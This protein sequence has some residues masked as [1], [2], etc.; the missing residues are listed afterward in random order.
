MLSK[1]DLGHCDRGVS[2]VIVTSIWLVLLASTQPIGTAA[3]TTAATTGTSFQANLFDTILLA[4]RSVTRVKA[5]VYT[6]IVYLMTLPR[7]DSFE[8]MHMSAFTRAVPGTS[9]IDCGVCD[10]IRP[11][12]V[13]CDRTVAEHTCAHCLPQGYVGADTQCVGEATSAVGDVL[14]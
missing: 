5:T 7:C 10:L 12:N 13:V 1:S 3:S 11:T 8:S 2:T 6:A 4:I 14:N 9:L